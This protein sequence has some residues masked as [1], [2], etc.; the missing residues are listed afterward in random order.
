MTTQNVDL[1]VAATIAAVL[2]MGAYAF[3]LWLQLWFLRQAVGHVMRTVTGGDHHHS[4]GGGGCGGFL[5][6]LLFMAI[7]AGLLLYLAS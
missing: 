2:I 7:V 6:L 5:T 4:G 3:W 1:L